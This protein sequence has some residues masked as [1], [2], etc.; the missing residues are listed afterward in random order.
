MMFMYKNNYWLNLCVEITKAELGYEWGNI[1]SMKKFNII[2]PHAFS[3]LE[4]AYCEECSSYFAYDNLVVI[5]NTLGYGLR[6]NGDYKLSL[7]CY[8][9]ALSMQESTLGKFSSYRSNLYY[10]IAWLYEEELEYDLALEWY[11]KDLTICEAVHG[12][13][14]ISTAHTYNSMG[15]LYTKMHEY[16][17]A[18]NYLKRALYIF[19]TRFGE[20]NSNTA[21]VCNNI[22]NV[23]SEKH[24]YN[25]AI[26]WHKRDIKICETI[27]G[28]E[29]IDTAISYNN[30]GITYYD[31][32]LPS[33]ALDWYEKAIKIMINVLEQEHPRLE[34]VIR[35][36]KKAF[37]LIGGMPG[38]FNSWLKMITDN[39]NYT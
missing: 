37:Y 35:N 24:L 18:Q 4:H 36:A 31:M 25:Q 17:I 10:N 3:V 9:R 23:Y 34:A 22:A 21:A 32:N 12:K 6:N 7:I 19:K 20:Y 33:V 11:K 14:G 2:S 28:K 8:K 39:V 1:E 27:N 15:S 26:E 38:S 5:A 29:H 30:I 16:K 13:E